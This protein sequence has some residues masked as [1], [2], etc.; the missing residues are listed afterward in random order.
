[1]LTVTASIWLPASSSILRK[2]LKRVVLGKLLSPSLESVLSSTSQMAT[3]S[4]CRL[5]SAESLLPLPPTP[6]QAKR[7]RS[8]GD[9]LSWATAVLTNTPTLVALAAFRNRRRSVKY[10]MTQA[11]ELVDGV[12]YKAY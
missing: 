9:L 3:M 2:S 11:P 10:D 5:A 1:M 7:I 8:L 4:P 6:I 12:A